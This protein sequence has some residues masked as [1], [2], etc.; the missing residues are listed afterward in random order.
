MR[1]TRTSL[2]G[3]AVAGALAACGPPAPAEFV[4]VDT[5]EPAFVVF[6]P[7]PPNRSEALVKRVIAESG[8]PDAL[9]YISWSDF[10]AAIRSA[11]EA[12]II[13]NDFHGTALPGGIVCLMS[14]APGSWGITWN[15]GIAVTRTDYDHARAS[16]ATRTA[17]TSSPVDP[18]THL[19]PLG[20]L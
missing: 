14:R 7:V 5:R 8:R 19:A 11:A 16:Y 18:R 9:R 1:I 2:A 17:E 10:P 20:C 13:R 15:G 12:V 6:N 4:L 3:L